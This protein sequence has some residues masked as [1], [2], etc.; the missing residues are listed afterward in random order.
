MNKVS[1]TFL[2]V[3][4]I[5]F[6]VFVSVGIFLFLWISAENIQIYLNILQFLVVVCWIIVAYL[7][8]EE[9]IRK[10]FKDEEILVKC[11]NEKILREWQ[12][13]L[14]SWRSTAMDT[15]WNIEIEI[16][17]F[18]NTHI[19]FKQA[20]LEVLYENSIKNTYSDVW[21]SKSNMYFKWEKSKINLN[22]PIHELLKNKKELNRDGCYEKYK[23]E[24]L[25]LKY[26]IKFSHNKNAKSL[27]LIYKNT[28]NYHN[29]NLPI[30]SLN[31]EKQYIQ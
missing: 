7:N 31:F 3:L 15:I 16:Q 24:F 5:W 18:W 27:I 23:G 21:Y 9:L 29:N 8:Y 11:I 22:L 13:L 17:N 19:Y 12:E 1:K 25:E 30:Y 10:N 20:D 6:V 2:S 4:I 26:I 14:I 28:L